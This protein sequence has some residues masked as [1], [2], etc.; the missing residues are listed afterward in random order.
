MPPPYAARLCSVLSHVAAS[1]RKFRHDLPSIHVRT[2]DYYDLECVPTTTD[3][4][5][6]MEKGETRVCWLKGGGS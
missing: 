4:G 2:D 1:S 6:A 5:H 3:L